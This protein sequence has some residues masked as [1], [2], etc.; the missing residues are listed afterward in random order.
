MRRVS[1]VL[2]YQTPIHRLL[3][4]FLISFEESGKSSETDGERADVSLFFFLHGLSSLDTKEGGEFILSRW[5]N[6]LPSLIKNHDFL[7]SL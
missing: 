1:V 4:G 5:R 3:S 7:M 2:R 6:S